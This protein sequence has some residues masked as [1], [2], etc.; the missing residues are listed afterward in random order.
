MSEAQEETVT[1]KKSEY[2][3]IIEILKRLRELLSRL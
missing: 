3:E 2:L 1:L